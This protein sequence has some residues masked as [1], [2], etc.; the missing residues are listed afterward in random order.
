MKMGD[1]GGRW[2]V[3]CPS[4]HPE[5]SRELREG[6]KLHYVGWSSVPSYPTTTTNTNGCT[7]SSKISLRTI[8]DQCIPQLECN[9]LSATFCEAIYIFETSFKRGSLCSITFL[10]FIIVLIQQVKIIKAQRLGFTHNCRSEHLL[11][12]LRLVETDMN[13]S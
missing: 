2:W 9:L 13:I 11:V 5:S 8:S 3:L 6:N 4:N 7:K 10:T 12:W 1:G